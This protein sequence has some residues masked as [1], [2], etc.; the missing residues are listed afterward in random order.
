[1]HARR[2]AGYTLIELLVVMAILALAVALA[3]PALLRARAGESRLEAVIASARTAAAARGETI[4][5]RIEPTG[6]WHMEGGASALERD[7]SDGRITALASVPLTL[8]ITPAGSCAFDV[9]SAAAA[10]RTV[11]LDPLTC[12]VRATRVATSL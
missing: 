9:R 10:A 11:T 4:Y 7:S 12:T 1:M 6:S 8:L 5:L 3:L 2:P